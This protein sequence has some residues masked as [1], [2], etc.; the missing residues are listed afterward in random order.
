MKDDDDER[1]EA[2]LDDP[3]SPDEFDADDADDRVPIDTEPCPH[4]RRPVYEQAE[5][6]PHCRNYISREDAPSRKPV[7]IVVGT[8]VCLAVVVFLWIL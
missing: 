8:L 3:E 7:W 4:C 6:C 2:W 5:V 1:D